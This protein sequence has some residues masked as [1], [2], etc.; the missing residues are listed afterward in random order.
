MTNVLFL[1]I[2]LLAGVALRRGLKLG[3][4]ASRVINAVL[5]YLCL[6][7]LTLLY[8]S[9]LHVERRYALAVAM[10]WVVFGGSWLFF[11][12]MQPRLRL[13][14]QTRAVLTLTAGIP[15]VSFVGFP[16]FELLYGAEGLRVG[17]VMSQAGSFLVCSTVGILMASYYAPGQLAAPPTT[18]QLLLNVLRFPTFGAFVVALVLNGA[19]WHWPPLLRDILTRL[20]SPFSFLALVS[21]GLQLDFRAASWRSRP[22]WWGLGYKLVLA[23]ALTAVLVLTLLQQRGPVA[24]LCVLG[25]GLGPMNTI[26]VV[27]ASYN[28]DPPLAARMIGIGIP[29]SLISVALLYLLI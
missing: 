8:A 14:S 5:V 11:R 23:P 12:F 18:R 19:G 4:N 7:S 10:P 26:A 25:A 29:L 9:E 22:L 27:A 2:C 28:L 13:T 1:L 21:V 24:E 15:S 3:D 17:V 16:I 6:P 20:G